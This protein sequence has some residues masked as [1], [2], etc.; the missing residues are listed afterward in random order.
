MDLPSVFWTRGTLLSINQYWPRSST[1]IYSSLCQVLSEQVIWLGLGRAV[2][3]FDVLLVAPFW[4][5]IPHDN[6]NC[7]L[8]LNAAAREHVLSELSD[9]NIEGVMFWLNFT[10]RLGGIATNYRIHMHKICASSAKAQKANREN[11]VTPLDFTLSVVLF[12]N[13]HSAITFLHWHGVITW[14]YNKYNMIGAFIHAFG[15]SRR[16]EAWMGT[17]VVVYSPVYSGWRFSTKAA[18]PSS[19]S[20]AI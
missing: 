17:L 9:T 13:G 19:R 18:R 20:F 6:N 1:I 10:F 8:D 4:G 11:K 2:H 16:G 14:S 15:L 12:S 3:L 5:A 7:R